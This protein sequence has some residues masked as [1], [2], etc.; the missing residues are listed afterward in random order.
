MTNSTNTDKDI[1]QGGARSRMDRTFLKV[2]TTGSWLLFI[3][4][5][6]FVVVSLFFNPVVFW[7]ELVVMLALLAFY[8]YSARS[9]RKDLIKYIESITYNA[10][11]ASKSSLLSFP[12]PIAVVDTTG[13]LAWHNEMFVR[14]FDNGEAPMFNR[15]IQD[16][17]PQLSAQLINEGKV[18]QPIKADFVNRHFNIFFSMPS[19]SKSSANS[20]ITMYFF[21]DTDYVR[22]KAEIAQKKSSV[23]IVLI[24][25]YEEIL[26]LQK[27]SSLSGSLTQIDELITTWISRQGGIVQKYDRDRYL[28]VV[29]ETFIQRAI[30]DKFAILEAAKTYCVGANKLPITLSIGIGR[31]F[32]SFSEKFDAA[33]SAID[34]ALGRGGDQVVMKSRGAFEYYGGK[35]TGVEKRTK[36]RSRVIA[37]ALR[38]L[39]VMSDNV[40]IMGHKYADYDA[41]GSCIGIYRACRNLNASAKIVIDPQ[42]NMVHKMLDR[43][44]TKEG[45]GSAFISPQEAENY[46]TPKTLLCILDS[47]RYDYCEMPSL[48]TDV[49]HI[50]VIDHHRRSEQFIENATLTYHEPYTSSTSE[51]VTEMLQYL[52][53][54][55]R[56]DRDEADALLC[57]IMLD[58]KNFTFKTGVRTFEAAA[59]LRRSG[60]DTVAAK[61]FFSTEFDS[62]RLKSEIVSNTQIYRNIMAISEYTIRENEPNMAQTKEALAMAADELISITQVQASFVIGEAEGVSHI[63]ARSHG[64]VNVQMILEKLGGGGHQTMAGAQVKASAHEAALL[65]KAAIDSYIDN[66]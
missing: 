18:T 52:G 3:V 44:R 60:A 36:V 49:H 54:A 41:I 63:S 1:K 62:Y 66:N 6:A 20:L 4:L 22:L 61:K 45:Y 26:S 31:D 37:T 9:R 39:I 17:F 2:F 25:N 34:M 11:S 28:F 47:H 12:L 21:E 19:A 33:K 15:S 48:I 51:M 65:L 59:Y 43:F 53:D 58:T 27:E 55:G 5:A 57:G 40:L 42:K 23:G 10:G 32:G 16:I 38:E 8:I 29:Q 64:E 46:V 30:D 13:A 24:D 56:I 35:S 14:T 50:A 7:I